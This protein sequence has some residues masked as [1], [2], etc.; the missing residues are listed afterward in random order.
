MKSRLHAHV[1]TIRQLE[2]LLA[3]HDKGSIKEAAKTL[4]LTQPTVSIQM[5]KL[6]QAMGSSLF[7]YANRQLLF[8]DIGLALVKTAVEVLDSFARLDMSLGNIKDFKSGTLRLA[9]VTTSKYFIPHLLGPFLEQYP[10]IDIQLKIGN[11]EQT[12]ERLKQGVD[13]FYVFSHPPS[14]IETESIEFLTNP[15]VA[16]AHEDHPIARKK[17][18][19]LKD[20]C[21]EPFLMREKGS[22]TRHAIEEFLKQHKAKINVKMTIES[23]EAIK[24]SVMSKLGI[25]ILSAHTLTYG[26]QSGLVRLPI[27]ELPINSHWFFVWSKSKRQT[28]IAAK[29]LNHIESNGRALLQKEMSR[30]GIAHSQVNPSHQGGQ[31]ET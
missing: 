16:I 10:D 9:V 20:I 19:T 25:S 5:K 28:L 24:H 15:L 11:R 8:T 18:L 30:N 26:G 6:A 22:G 17:D 7:N 4:F 13:D 21:N 2:I 14:D 29:F 1:G 3:V 31:A 12:I 27:K 23:N